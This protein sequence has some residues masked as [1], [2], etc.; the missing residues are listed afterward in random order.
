RWEEVVESLKVIFENK[1]VIGA[2]IVEF[3]PKVNFDAEAYSLAK[4][5]YKIM[6]LNVKTNPTNQQNL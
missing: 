6:A 2:D 4:L 3:A 1:E 5:T